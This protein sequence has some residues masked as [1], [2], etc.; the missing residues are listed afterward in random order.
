MLAIELA[1]DPRR[2]E[3]LWGVTRDDSCTGNGYCEAGEDAVGDVKGSPDLRRIGEDMVA[4][5]GIVMMKAYV[6]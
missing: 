2:T 3:L 5:E 4:R 6:D 1:V